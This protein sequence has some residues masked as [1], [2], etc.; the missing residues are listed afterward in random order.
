MDRTNPSPRTLVAY[1]FGRNPQFHKAFIYFL[2]TV[3]EERCS[4]LYGP[5]LHFSTTK[6]LVQFDYIELG[7]SRIGDMDNLPNYNWLFTFPDT[8]FENEV[9]ALINV[10]IASGTPK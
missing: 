4:R 3:G 9:Q 8:C 5:S 1:T 2:P 10:C 7:L 6:D